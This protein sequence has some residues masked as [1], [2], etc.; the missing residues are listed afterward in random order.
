MLE[1]KKRE[2]WHRKEKRQPAAGKITSTPKTYVQFFIKA[3][4]K[5]NNLTATSLIICKSF[6]AIQLNNSY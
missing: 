6:I 5:L 4:Q 1:T 2:R 3:G